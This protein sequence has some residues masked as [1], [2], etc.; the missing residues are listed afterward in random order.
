MDPDIFGWSRSDQEITKENAK[1]VEGIKLH[2]NF[3]TPE[4]ERSLIDMIDQQE[5]IPDLKR[6]VQ[7]YG[8]KYDYRSR[9]IDRSSYI[10]KI[11]NWMDFILDR[12]QEQGVI[13][14][15]PDQ[16]IINEYIDDQGIAPHIDCEPCFGD[17]IISISLSGNCVINFQRNINDKEGNKIPLFIERRSLV[18][19]TENSRYL[20]FHGI[21]PRKT[22]KFNGTV[23]H[24]RRR[25]SITFRKVILE[26]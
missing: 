23:H 3:I 2:F 12:L 11:P 17:T 14:F 26:N 7:H 10:G 15:R 19:M 16:A 24:R 8:Y 25:I 20:W 5:W 6:R 18:I 4:E 22:D 21:P 1:K 9:S 13:S